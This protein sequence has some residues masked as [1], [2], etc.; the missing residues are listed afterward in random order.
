MKPELAFIGRQPIVNLQQEIVA[1][2]LFFRDSAEADRANVKD[3][4]QASAQ[5]LV[6]TL[7]EIGAENLLNDKQAF[8]LVDA[9]LLH[10]ELVELLPPAKTVLELL[11]SVELNE[12][13]A[14]R[15]KE[16]QKRGYQLALR[17]PGTGS[18]NLQF[19]ANYIKINILKL[20]IV[21]AE[22][23]F[24]LYRQLPLKIIAEK[25]ENRD[26]FLACKKIGFHLIQ[27]FYFAR[28]ETF[29]AKVINPS[30]VSVLELLNL[31]SRDADMIE[32]DAGFK[33]DPALAFKLLRYINSVG[34]G[35]SC[36]IHS[37]R[38]ALT[39]IGTRQLYR[40]LTLLMVTA[41]HNS[42][43]SALM[44]TSI[45]RG[46]LTELLGEHYFD[47][48]GQDDLFII[49]IFSLLDTILEQP[50]QE[51]LDKVDLPA[52]IHEALMTRQ[53]IYGPFLAL[54]EACENAD[55]LRI[56]ALAENLH[57][58]PAQVNKCHLAALAWVEEFNL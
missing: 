9:E 51:V 25:V 44:K 45:T 4:L 46:R 28:P 30:F 18:L 26:Q 24:S 31:V 57:I 23:R 40:W 41:G 34:F 39:V 33:R 48:A 20:G 42:S 27:G 55:D 47:K 35:L 54:T 8:I 37:V 49:G 19:N 50:M 36:E 13:N 15:C 52:A 2:E 21:E 14:A 11:D 6:N 38:H 16:L 12:A 32:I 7:S 10:N 3:N 58:N 29:T 56:L 5:V 43:S 1:Y 53:G 17:D 22:K